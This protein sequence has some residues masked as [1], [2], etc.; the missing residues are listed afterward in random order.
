MRKL[1]TNKT[2]DFFI[3]SGAKLTRVQANRLGLSIIMG[4]L[5][6][7]LKIFVDVPVMLGYFLI[8]FFFFFGYFYLGRKIFK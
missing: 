6:I 3:F 2:E 1:N 7:F 8:F 5:G 4:F